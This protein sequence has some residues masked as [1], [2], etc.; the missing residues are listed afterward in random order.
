M[1]EPKIAPVVES[2]EEATTVTEAVVETPAAETKTEETI[3][4]VLGTKEPTV[5]VTKPDVK[6]VP[7]ATYLELKREF[8]A[9]KKSIA[10]GAT[11]KE[12]SADLKS[13]A[14]KHNVDQDF[15]EELAEV[16]KKE[17]K[18]DF[19][20]ELASKLKPIQEKDRQVKINNAF[21]NAFAKAIEKAPEYQGIVNKEVIKTLSL[22][23]RNANKTFNQ[24]IDE[25][26]GH[27]V[28]GKRTLD[29]TGGSSRV[30]TTVDMA[31]AKT[32]GEYF[33]KVMADPVLKEQYN[34][35]LPNR[36]ST[37]L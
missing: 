25:S 5:E 37:Y 13:L 27:L 22:D 8:K 15:L 33:K 36:L 19:E 12:V 31:K 4:E 3:S 26:Y 32:D 21:E 20:E 30:E 23:P 29:A 6:M 24:L 10:D 2:T 34:K 28:T 9:L 14:E 7:E 17:S 1:E 35:D 16:M 18:S 11:N